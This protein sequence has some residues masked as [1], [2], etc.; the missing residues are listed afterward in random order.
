MIDLQALPAPSVVE[1]LSYE[2]ILAAAKADFAERM[3][4]HLPA[5]DDILA[6]ESDPVVMLL[7]SHAF[8]ELL[9]RARI[10]DAARAHLLAFATGADLDQLAAL[11]GVA[12]MAGETDD[13]LRERLQRRIAA[14]GAQGTAEHYEYHAMSASPLVRTARASQAEPGAVVLMLWISDQTQAE[15]VRLAV[16]QAIAARGVRILGVPVD[17]QVAVPRTIDITARIVRTRSA[18]ADLLPQLRARLAAAIAGIDALAGSVARSYIT[19]VLHV[20]GVHAVE[21]PDPTTPAELTPLA[22]GEF[23]ALGTVQLI[24]GGMA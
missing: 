9:I 8:R 1:E 11:F 16:A 18:P 24:D 22:V 21:Y 6:L 23:P 7:Q 14:L 19:T 13:R 3:R 10:N 15:A 17:V 2:A 20:S 12:R 5:I 4:P